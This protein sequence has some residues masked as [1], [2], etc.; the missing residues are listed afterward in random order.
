MCHLELGDE[1]V[2]SP[3]N[4]LAPSDQALDEFLHLW[5]LEWMCH[6][7]DHVLDSE[8]KMT[9]CSVFPEMSAVR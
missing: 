4:L 5:V 1:A 6:E 9:Q 8:G 3:A 2:C 7:M